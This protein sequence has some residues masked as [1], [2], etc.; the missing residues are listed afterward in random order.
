M[1]NTP[2]VLL[3]DKNNPFLLKTTL[4]AKKIIATY[5]ERHKY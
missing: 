5:A 3:K 1:R 4:F 2:N